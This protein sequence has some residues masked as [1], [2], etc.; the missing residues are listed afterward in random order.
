MDIAD[1][2][3]TQIFEKQSVIPY[4]IRQF[5][6]LL[7]QKAIEKFSASNKI[8]YERAIQLVCHYLLRNW[9]L[10]ACFHELHL[11]GLTKEFYLG[12]YCKKNL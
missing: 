9:L 12:A 10:K 6:K 5:C 2:I 11:E 4:S 8:N 1:A 7:Y 3:L